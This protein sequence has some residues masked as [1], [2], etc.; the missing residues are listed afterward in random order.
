MKI[1]IL[2]SSGQLGD[3]LL[4]R[5]KEHHIFT[6]DKR[7][8]DINN[9]DKTYEILHHIK[10]D[11]IIHAA[12]YTDIEACEKRPEIAYRVNAKG[13]ENIA[14]IAEAINSKLIYIS[15]DYVFD[16]EKGSPYN[17]D[18]TP[19]P[20]NYYGKTKYEGELYIQQYMEKYY[21][22]RTAALFGHKGKNFIKT[23]LNLVSKN[24]ILK[25]VIDQISSI[26]YTEDLAKAIEKLIINKGNYGIYH[27]VNEGHCSWYDLA[28]ETFKI[29]NIDAKVAPISLTDVEKN[30]SRPRNSSL[31][32]NSH[33][34]LPP[35]EEALRTYLSK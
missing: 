25:V 10:P 15:T 29:K 8:I 1:C 6:F 3:E 22:I 7:T 12:A 18:D 11:S 9:L 19:N 24:T 21:I 26:T 17:E 27:F 20:I 14:K 31:K 32:N 4:N 5:F 2:G 33:I 34:K 16:G 23:T 30:I 28:Q 35:W 13:T